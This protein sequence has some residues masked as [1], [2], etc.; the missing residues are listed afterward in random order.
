M[1]KL[2]IPK[3]SVFKGFLSLGWVWTLPWSCVQVHRRES[4]GWNSLEFS[5]EAPGSH[6]SSSSLVLHPHG[7][8]S[9]DKSISSC[10]RSRGIQDPAKIPSSGR[11]KSHFSSFPPLFTPTKS[12]LFPSLKAVL[13]HLEI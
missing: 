8:S 13:K 12:L 6:P 7:N 2:S 3:D 4:Q 5:P 11:Q 10:P 1:G 9:P